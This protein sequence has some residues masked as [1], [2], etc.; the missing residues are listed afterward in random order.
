[1][2]TKDVLPQRDVGSSSTMDILSVQPQLDSKKRDLRKSGSGPR[3]FVQ[4]MENNQSIIVLNLMPSISPSVPIKSIPQTINTTTIQLPSSTPTSPRAS[5]ILP[6]KANNM[7]PPQ[8]AST[9]LDSLASTAVAQLQASKY[10]NQFTRT[11]VITNMAKVPSQTRITIDVNTPLI[12]TKTQLIP[13]AHAS[14]VIPPLTNTPNVAQP[15]VQ[16]VASIMARRSPNLPR[17]NAPAPKIQDE[18]NPSK[19]SLRSSFGA[20]NRASNV[21][22]DP[23]GVKACMGYSE[24][25]KKLELILRQMPEGAINCPNSNYE[26]PLI[27]YLSGKQLGSEK[28]KLNYEV[29][30]LLASYGAD[31]NYVTPEGKT[32]LHYA[33]EYIQPIQSWGKEC[34][35]G[36]EIVLAL[37]ENGAKMDWLQSEGPFATNLKRKEELSQVFQNYAKSYFDLEEPVDIRIDADLELSAKKDL[38]SL[39]AGTYW[40]RGKITGKID[41]QN[42][43]VVLFNGVEY[44]KDP[45]TVNKNQLRKQRILT[46]GYHF[47]P[48]D[49][50]EFLYKESVWIPCTILS[51][52]TTQLRQGLTVKLAN[53]IIWRQCSK[54]KLS[55]APKE[56][57]QENLESLLPCYGMKQNKRS[58]TDSKTSFSDSISMVEEPYNDLEKSL[59]LKGLKP[60][61][62]EDSYDESDR[63][64]QYEPPSPLPI[65]GP[66]QVMKIPLVEPSEGVYIKK[67]EE[68]AVSCPSPRQ[69][70]KRSFQAMMDGNEGT[71]LEELETVKRMRL[72][73]DANKDK[74]EVLTT[75][76]K[77]ISDSETSIKV[78]KSKIVE[79]EAEISKQGDSIAQ[80]DLSMKQL[81]MEYLERKKALEAKKSELS[82]DQMFKKQSLKTHQD[83]LLRL[84]FDLRTN[85]ELLQQFEND[86]N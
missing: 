83:L 38:G 40:R 71:S 7:A 28:D 70:R 16:S 24:Y 3:G 63:F 51:I 5:P 75:L 72:M 43:N 30:L 68:A 31:P 74:G 79:V 62:E 1:M 59:A 53:D 39:R 10:P 54:F 49:R 82:T 12:A 81:E 25:F 36:Q 42:F 17:R 9:A 23:N 66:R 6:R 56:S 26:T 48:D 19:P 44:E 61:L 20:Q 55:S 65:Q 21:G 50:A 69:T 11:P 34:L 76:K 18:N 13:S 37:I 32:A 60:S 77:T 67:E 64:S 86:K 80:V 22:S 73:A 35:Y 52:P 46:S 29:V 8:N 58:R 4:P 14:N 85:T 15:P 45:I 33:F 41:E 78:I 47:R 27:S 84:N 2:N 57:W